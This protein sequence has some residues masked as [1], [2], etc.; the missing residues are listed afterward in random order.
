[1]PIIKLKPRPL[2]AYTVKYTGDNI[3]EVESLVGDGIIDPD[4]DGNLY[5][6]NPC[7]PESLVAHPGDYIVKN[8]SGWPR[9]Y[10]SASLTYLFD[11]ISAQED[12]RTKAWR[13]LIDTYISKGV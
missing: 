12:E 8:D 7:G 5:L 13:D 4:L 6:S 1:M 9:V 2:Y 3:E 10:D 11:P